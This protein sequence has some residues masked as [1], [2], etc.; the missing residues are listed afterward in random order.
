MEETIFT[1]FPVSQLNLTSLIYQ[2]RQ[3]NGVI[4]QDFKRYRVF[5]SN[6]VKNLRKQLKLKSLKQT[7]DKLANIFYLFDNQPE[8]MLKDYKFLHLI[9][10]ECERSWA[11]S[12]EIKA[13]TDFDIRKRYHMFGKLKKTAKYAELLGKFSFEALK[14]S[15]INKQCFEEVKAYWLTSLGLHLFE[16]QCWESALKHLQQAHDS[17]TNLIPND[18]SASTQTEVYRAMLKEIDPNIRFCSYRIEQGFDDEEENEVCKF[19]LDHNQ[20]LNKIEQFSQEA[21][22]IET[23]VEAEESGLNQTFNWWGNTLF[24]SNFNLCKILNSI[25]V[26]FNHRQT[27]ISKVKHLI[28]QLVTASQLAKSIITSF[29]QSGSTNASGSTQIPKEFRQLLNMVQSRLF[30]SQASLLLLTNRIYLNGNSDKF[31]YKGDYQKFLQT[32]KLVKNQ[33][34]NITN[35]SE[36]QHDSSMGN[37]IQIQLNYLK[38]LYF[39]GQA[40]LKNLEGKLSLSYNIFKEV[41]ITLE[42]VKADFESLKSYGITIDNPLDYFINSNDVD[43]LINSTKFELLQILSN[44]TLLQSQSESKVL[45]DLENLSLRESIKASTIENLHQIPQYQLISSENS[46]Q[47]R[48]EPPLVR[49]PPSCKPIPAKPTLFDVA[50]Q[51]T[52]S[53]SLSLEDRLNNRVNN[54]QSSGLVGGFLSKFF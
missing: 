13:L 31:S 20:A 2:S 4:N 39:F 22:S 7:D 52:D 12:M 26:E 32:L 18:P 24:V 48:V 3:S 30:F 35:L 11:Y 29:Q 14:N 43:Y 8:F 23:K 47:T 40:K 5:C 41:E 17:Y 46:S 50:Y 25:Q 16:R 45:Q 28:T 1:K 44:Y 37:F 51:F 54:A 27:D 34:I 38:A 21:K 6:K 15:L 10:F 36:Y 49:L 19:E 42:E 33:L 9:L 53:S